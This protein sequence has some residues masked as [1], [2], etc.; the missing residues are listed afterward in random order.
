MSLW[1]S[2]N[3]S[4][5]ND[6]SYNISHSGEWVV[7]AVHLFPIGIDVEKVGKLHLDIAERYFTEEENRDLLDKS[8][9]EQLSYF[10]DLWSRI[11]ISCKCESR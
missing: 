6:F 7:C 4:N 2:K 11:Q 8:K 9:D 3:E 1:K 10:F 5:I